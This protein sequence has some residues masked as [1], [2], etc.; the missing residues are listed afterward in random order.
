MTNVEIEELVVR[1][2]G[3]I[4]LARTPE[5]QISVSPGASLFGGDGPLDSL[6]LV[7]LL[8]DIEEALADRGFDVTLSDARAMS[9]SQSPFRSVPALV[10]YIHDSLGAER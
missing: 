9:Q 7:S 10:A 4:N 3:N 1:A 2:V 8:M 6:G 5:A